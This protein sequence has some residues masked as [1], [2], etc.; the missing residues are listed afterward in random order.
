[1]KTSTLQVEEDIRIRKDMEKIVPTYDAYMKK[2]T[3][4]RERTLRERTIT[5]AGIQPG[6]TVLEV[7]CG[8]GTLTLAAKR[9]A[10]PSGRVCG[11]D[12]IPAMIEICKK[13]ATEAGQ[14]VLFQEGSIEDLPFPD[15]QFD[16]V[17]CSFMI[18]HMSEGVRSK[19]MQEMFRVLKPGGRLLLIDL[20][21]PPY[22]V[23]RFI[24][25]RV[26]RWV[27]KDD[28]HELLPL[29]EVT[30]FTGVEIAPVKF[31][32]MGVALLSYVRGYAAKA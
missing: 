16:V 11:I 1:M 3:M 2:I 13:K 23:S 7:G 18:F 8:T 14:D 17:M 25:N 5:L 20:T 22:P 28:L 4:G 29:L 31:R 15:N 30:G 19:G 32:I 21:L 27:G 9:Q 6:N 26:L 12:L 24:A 10:G